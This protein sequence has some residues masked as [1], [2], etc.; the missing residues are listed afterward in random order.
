MALS[1]E[2]ELA[3]LGHMTVRELQTRF[4]SIFGQPARS[5]HRDWLIR[6]IAWRL[7]ANA[8]GDLSERARR[9][10]AELA[11]DSDLRVTPPSNMR[12]Y[13]TGPR[14][15]DDALDARLPAIGTQITRQYK[16]QTLTVTVV[17]GGF[18]F[19]GEVLPTL[20]AVAK[21]VT[22]SHWNGFHFF[23]LPKREAKS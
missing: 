5:R 2:R 21:R 4:A 23:G 12:N 9:R 18:E 17:A 22:G 8:E 20:S 10:A 1:I 14:R 3:A 7:Q 15:R 11:N 13:P 19:R 6:R 16:G